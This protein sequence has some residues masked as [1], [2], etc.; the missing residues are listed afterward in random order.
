MIFEFIFK[1]HTLKT[2]GRILFSLLF[3]SLLHSCSKDRV[4]S[5]ETGNNSNFNVDESAMLQL[6]NQ[7]R[8]AGCNCGS[9]Y[10]PPVGA[11]SWNDLLAQA[12]YDHSK[13]MNENDYFAHNSPSGSTPGTRIRAVG[14][15]WST[16]GE[17]IAH[18]YPNEQ[19]VM[20]GWLASEG[21]CRNIMNGNFREMGVGREGA[22]WTQDFGA[23]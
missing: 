17:N 16:I 2:V 13:D 23:R 8:S 11:V 4:D 1:I 22:Y 19:A 15:N 18:N 20:N 12:A 10:M 7:V 5:D 6:V 3:L 9:T 21:H 14:Y